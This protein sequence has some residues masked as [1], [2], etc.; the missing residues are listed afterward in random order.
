MTSTSGSALQKIP[1]MTAAL[2][3]RAWRFSA[4]FGLAI[5]YIYLLDLDRAKALGDLP[6][7]GNCPPPLGN[8]LPSGD[9]EAF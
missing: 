2:V 6:R 8:L 5:S 3:M 4:V 7:E 9:R 1:P